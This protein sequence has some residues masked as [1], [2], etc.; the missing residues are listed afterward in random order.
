MLISG[1]QRV[2][3]VHAHPDDETLATGALIA[4]LAA[5]SVEV[6]LV[7]CTRGERGELVAGVL[8][9]DASPVE[10]VRT[11]AGELDAA[12]RHLGIRKHVFLGTPPASRDGEHRIHED[13]GMQWIR[14][15]L[16]GPADD[17]S[18]NAF[19]R[20]PLE[21]LVADLLAWIRATEPE[22][23]LSYDENGGYGHP[24]HV[25]AHRVARRAAELA[26]LPFLEF[27]PWY[28]PE[29]DQPCVEWDDHTDQ[30]AALEA[31]HDSHRTQFTRSG[32]LVTHV[33]GQQMPLVTRIG[34]R[35]G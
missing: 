9:E 30:L 14:P 17:S 1:F 10:L 35:R 12:T 27:I 28:G 15:G 24:D 26:G 20:A 3:F 29:S 11:R 31:A 23:V 18:S 16:A 13:S 5:D 25:Q 8:P 33:G 34:L 7:T 2:V 19:S 6:D 32:N 4:Q 21:E 22:A